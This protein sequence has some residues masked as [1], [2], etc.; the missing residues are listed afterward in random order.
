[1][2]QPVLVAANQLTKH[3]EDMLVLDR[4]N[5]EIREGDFVA[6]LGPSGSGKSTLL[7]IIT[8]LLPPD[9]GTVRYRGKPVSGPCPQTAMVFQ[10]FAL[11]PWLTVLENVE[12]G[13]K[14]TGWSLEERRG[15]A[16][17]L[18]DLVG[19]DGFEDA[20]PKELSGGMRQRVGFARA[21]A[22]EPELLCMDEPF[23]ALDVLT[24]ENL[25]SELLDLWIERKIPTRSVLMVTHGIEEAVF[26][27][28][29]III[30]SRNP[31]RVVADLP[32]LLP[33]PRNRKHP[34]FLAMVDRVYKIVSEADDLPKD[35]PITAAGPGSAAPS[36]ARRLPPLPGAPVGML[37]GLLELVAD[38]GGRDD[39]Y[40]LGS[41]LLMEVDDLLPVTDAAEL[42]QFATVREGDL[43]LTGLGQRFADADILE[44]KELFAAQI[45]DLPLFAL[46]LR[47]LQGKRNRAMTRE[48]FEDLLAEE[49]SDPE[50]Q[51]QLHTAVAWGRYA[52]VFAYDQASEMF[53]LEDP[54][55][56][57]EGENS[58]GTVGQAPPP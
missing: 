37:T 13:L 29:R 24:A 50:V 18:I 33:R 12:I 47:V 58:T 31:A 6:L 28:D 7:R 51:A 19:L 44:R 57:D 38:R 54:E 55:D 52:E 11:Y 35:T 16:S 53:H 20:Y 17:G 46:I 39:L 9:G 49:F 14:A 4:I 43:Q 5:L 8:G 34:Q 56:E 36:G 15:K 22:V 32:V 30:L 26:M 48:F 1:M 45:R 2:A 23:S 25:R 40:R 27:A 3:Y 21:L 41:E 10:T 42:L